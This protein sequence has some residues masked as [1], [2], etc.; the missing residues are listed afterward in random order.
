MHLIYIVMERQAPMTMKMSMNRSERQDY[1]LSA[2]YS[3][4]RMRH[5]SG[6]RLKSDIWNIVT[7]I[8]RGTV[9]DVENKITGDNKGYP[10]V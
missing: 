8:M 2:I 1:I 7:M 5:I 4:R 9:F 10:V 6:K 3:A